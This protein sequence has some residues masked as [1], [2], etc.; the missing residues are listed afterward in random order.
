MSKTEK[1]YSE[2][3]VVKRLERELPRW[4][5]EAGWIKRSYRTGGWKGTLMVVN[6]VGHLAEAAWHH[7]DILATYPRVEV[8]LQTHTA[9]GVTDKDF[10]LARK[11]E[12]V[13]CWQPG[14]EGGAL[15]GTPAGDE[16]FTY[17]VYD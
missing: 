9:K 15:E 2:D 7:P 12:E 6:T 14:R 1:A 8:R 16:R 3:E 11:I 17:I 4:R 10:E 5:H 13:V